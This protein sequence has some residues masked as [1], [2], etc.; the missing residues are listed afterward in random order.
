RQPSP[1]ASRT[2][3]R[4]IRL[5]SWSSTTSTRISGADT[6]HDLCDLSQE[7]SHLDGLGDVAVEAGGHGAIRV[8]CHGMRGQGD[9]GNGMTGLDHAGGAPAVDVAG[10]GEVHEDEIEGLAIGSGD[11]LF[12]RDG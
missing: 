8:P 4:R 11:R 10:Q 5:S 7:G 1:R 9:D 3:L 2:I 12:P 6:T